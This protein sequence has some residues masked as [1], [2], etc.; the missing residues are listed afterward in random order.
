MELMYVWKDEKNDKKMYATEKQAELYEYKNNINLL[1]LGK[2]E[3]IIDTD[4]KVFTI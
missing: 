1:C 4:G 2:I 3:S